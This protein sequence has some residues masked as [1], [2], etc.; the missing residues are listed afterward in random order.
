M[1][2]PVRIAE[3]E[4]VAAEM[5]LLM[6][7]A[8]GPGQF[9]HF[10]GSLSAVD[11]LVA[12][13]FHKLRLHADDPAWPERDRFVLSKGHSVPAVYVCL[14]RC[15]FF[16]E[17]EL[18]T[19]KRLG[20]PLQ[21]HP[22]M[23]KT[24]GLEANT[25]S[26]GMGLSVANGLALA[27]RVTGLGYRVYTLL[28]DGE[29]QEGQVWEAAMTAAHH[30]L[31]NLT[32]LVDRNGLQAMG[33]TEDQMQVEPLLAKWQSFGWH[34]LETDGHDLRA[35]CEALD[36]AEMVE[37]CPSVIVAHTVKGKGVSFMRGQ[38]GFHNLAITEEQFRVAEAELE[39]R[40][41]AL[42]GAA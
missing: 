39:A 19:L 29:C 31:G 24:R 17:S 26:L 16:P 5:R 40:V 22:D 30:R 3:L 42:E 12:L 21:G 28:G 38:V 11:I 34:A 23:R 1:S 35:I 18:A 8:M 32:A 14:A 2:T 33:R 7:R 10:G 13:Y 41:R 9:H 37:G 6:V 15:G 36:A 20:S 25:G 4:R 27:A